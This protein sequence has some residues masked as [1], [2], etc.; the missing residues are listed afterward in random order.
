MME[1]GLH[2][3][4]DSLFPQEPDFLKEEERRQQD[5]EYLKRLYPK[6]MRL[7]A[8]VLEEYL[9]QYEYEGSPIYAQYP[10]AVTLYGMANKI[11]EQFSFS[12][13]KE[14]LS[15]IKEFIQIMVCQEIY[16]RRRRH[17]NFCRWFYRRIQ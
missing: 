2:Y 12:G 4:L 3:N 11:Y 7:V 6:E 15:R 8:S 10:D 13:S 16:V 9:D 17:D 5:Y 14:E 1:Q